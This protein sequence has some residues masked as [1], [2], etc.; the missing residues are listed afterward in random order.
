MSVKIVLS[1]MAAL[2]VMAW[3]SAVAAAGNPG[4]LAD[5]TA[6]VVTLYEASGNTCGTPLRVVPHPPEFWKLIPGQSQFLFKRMGDVQHK[7]QRIE[8]PPE[9]PEM[10]LPVF[11]PFNETKPPIA[12]EPCSSKAS[13]RAFPF[14]FSIQDLDDPHNPGNKKPHVLILVPAKA[15]N[16]KPPYTEDQFYLLVSTVR[17]ASQCKLIT[18]KKLRKGCDAMRGL[19]DMQANVSPASFMIEIWN[20]VDEIRP[21]L[22]PDGSKFHNGVIHGNY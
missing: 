8:P 20:R 15:L 22:L 9:D 10:D 11:Y 18:N 12:V 14:A 5:R 3:T 7:I 16:P 13:F 4:V 6:K 19:A 17:E 2:V 1:F 21:A